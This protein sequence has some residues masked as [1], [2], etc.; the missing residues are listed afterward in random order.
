MGL[1]D[2]LKRSLSGAGGDE[3]TGRA[4][5]V[6]LH[7]YGKLPIYKDFIQAGLA[8]EGAKEFREWIGNGFSRRWAYQEGYKAVVIPRHGFLLPLPASRRVIA[9]TL[10]GSHD[11]GGL[12]PF[13]FTLFA[14]LSPGRPA[15]D[16]FVALSHLAAFDERG[17]YVRRNFHSG[18]TLGNLYATFRGSRISLPIRSAGRIAKDLVDVGAEISVGEFA[19]GVFGKEAATLWPRFLKELPEHVA[20]AADEG[21]G[22][23]RIPIGEKLPPELQL[24]FWIAWLKERNALRDG[25]LKGFLFERSGE[26]GRAVLFFR[27]VR[28]EDFLLLHPWSTDYEFVEELGPAPQP[29]GWSDDAEPAPPKP[30]ETPAPL[31]AESV[32][33][34][35]EGSGAAASA[36]SDASASVTEISAGAPADGSA[37]AAGEGT[38][39]P[40]PAP[41]AASSAPLSGWDDPLSKLLEGA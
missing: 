21:P 7:L 25:A 29:E 22:A 30:S 38:A 20:A 4:D 5:V 15:S 12:R 26:R 33:P 31:E 24:Q 8:D 40:K 28:P 35:K 32:P 34:S 23:I 27:D 2:L 3:P 39:G 41:P 17:D 6:P 14:S 19:A 37:A 1:F 11:E 16:P 10:W 13:P 18:Q 36:L 9:G